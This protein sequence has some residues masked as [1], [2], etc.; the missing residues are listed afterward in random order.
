MNKMKLAIATAAA[1]LAATSASAIELGIGG[2]TA[3][4]TTTAEYNVDAENMSLTVEPE[5]GYA[6]AGMDFTAST[7]ISVYDD[8]FVLGDTMPTLDFK[9]AR[10]IWDNL[11]LYGEI[12][13]DFETEERT[14]LTVGASFKF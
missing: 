14:D 2:L 13:Y 5:V 7:E 9:A 6:F 12:G 10:Q 3:G 1:V 11:E 4:A 8:E